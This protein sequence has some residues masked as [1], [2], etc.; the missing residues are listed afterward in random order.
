MMIPQT[1]WMD[2]KF[3]FEFPVGHFPMIV[4]RLLGTP[5]RIEDMT[6]AIPAVILTKRLGDA[7][8]IQ[9]HAG[10]LIDLEELH[11]GRIDDYLANAGTLR[12]WDPANRKTYEANHNARPF[13]EI[14]D[15]FRR[16]R[17]EFV[18]RLLYYD[19]EMLSRSALHPRLKIPMRLVDMAFFIAEHDDHHLARMRG[20]L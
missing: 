16:V 12:G 10:H 14:K 11:N 4:E 15:Q 6:R 8:S 5:S 17:K 19:E 2:R 9:E 7:W 3:V 18:G 20:V 13:G 1:K